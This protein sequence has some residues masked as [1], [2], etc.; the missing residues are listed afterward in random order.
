[1]LTQ[2]LPLAAL[3]AAALWAAT[4]IGELVHTQSEGAFGTTA[5]YVLEAL[6]AS[7]V[8]AAALT[9]FLLAQ[10]ATSRASRG[11]AGTAAAGFALLTLSAL[12]SLAAGEHDSPLGVLFPLGLLIVAAGVVALIIESLRGRFEPR[13]F[14]PLLLVAFVV[15][16]PLDDEGG[17]LLVALPWL[18]LLASP[19]RDRTAA[20]PRRA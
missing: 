14:P 19:A 4:G 11:G 3:V 9:L 15:S 18:A 7:A 6:F 1:M 20:Q 12:A 13:W 2:R 8:A 5:D 10:R 16:I 17:P